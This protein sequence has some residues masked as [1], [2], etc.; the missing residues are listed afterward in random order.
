MNLN[1]YQ[2]HW[3]ALSPLM[4]AKMDEFVARM[5]QLVPASLAVTDA[6]ESTDTDEFRVSA[7]ITATPDST[8]VI[9]A[10]FKLMDGDEHGGEGV[11]VSFALTGYN[12]LV[13]GGYSPGMYTEDAF[14]HQT[15]ELIRRVN[16]FDPNEAAAYVMNEALSNATLR[17]ELSVAGIALPA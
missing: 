12:A 10:D 3:D 15:D 1:E 11:A 8:V 17:S 9:G 2:R 13:L 6:A 16:E 7:D 4:K 14:T 5:R